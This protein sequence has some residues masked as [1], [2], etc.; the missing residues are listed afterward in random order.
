MVGGGAIQTSS[1]AWVKG[2]GRSEQRVDDAED[3][4]VGADAQ[5]EDEDRNDG[6]AGV[7]D[8]SAEGVLQV[9]EK[10]VECHES[11]RLA[12]LVFRLFHAAE[13]HERKATRFGGRKAA[14]NV[15]VDGHFKMSCEFGFELGIKRGLVREGAALRPKERLR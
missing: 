10:N 8:Q 11:S 4:D 12:V 7:A 14:G 5:G 2:S 13:A 6:E 3:G 15:I 1:L 9:L